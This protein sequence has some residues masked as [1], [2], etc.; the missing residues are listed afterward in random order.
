MAKT[1]LYFFQR[2]LYIMS[3]YPPHLFRSIGTK[4]Y[5]DSLD[6]TQIEYILEETSCKLE[7]YTI[8]IEEYQK[9]LD[10]IKSEKT[11]FKNDII[12]L[13]K[14][15]ANTNNLYQEYLRYYEIVYKYIE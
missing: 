3:D 10:Y 11:T 2:V 13:E 9:H 15:I 4:L 6:Q 1:G 8:K 7:E 14:N 5:L 12:Q